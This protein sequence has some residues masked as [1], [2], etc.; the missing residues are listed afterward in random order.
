MDKKEFFKTN[1]SFCPAA[2]R[3]I[4]VN[5]NG[6][7]SLCCHARPVAKVREWKESKI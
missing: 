5:S 4:Y 3:E 1:K 6:R 2:F 7:Y